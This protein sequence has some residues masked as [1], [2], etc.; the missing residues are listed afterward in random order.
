MSLLSLDTALFRWINHTLAAPSIDALARGL[1]WAGEYAWLFAFLTPFVWMKTRGPWRLFWAL[2]LPVV[3]ISDALPNLLKVWF[4]RPRPFMAL[5]DT[6]LVMP[7]TVLSDFGFPSG[8]ATNSM[9][10]AALLALTAGRLMGAVAVAAAVLVC[11]SRVYIGVHYPLDVAAG[12]LLGALI[13]W[14]LLLAHRRWV[15]PA[16]NPRRAFGWSIAATVAL[17]LLIQVAWRVER[18]EVPS[19]YSATGLPEGANSTP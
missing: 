12:A 17:G 14:A 3:L 19:A 15:E 13:A 8:H 11:L 5:T 10:V 6:R 18:H 9:A 16:A 7:V 1:T 2:L 4:E